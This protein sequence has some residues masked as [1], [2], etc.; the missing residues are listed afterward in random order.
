MGM[1]KTSFLED[2]NSTGFCVS[3]FVGK[4]KKTS[5]SFKSRTV[6]GEPL[7]EVSIDDASD[8]QLNAVCNVLDNL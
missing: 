2:P 3:I 1:E 7:K 8:A 5:I 6:P 4:G